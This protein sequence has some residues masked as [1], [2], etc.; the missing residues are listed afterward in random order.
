MYVII[1][2]E[3]TG[4]DAKKH[5]VIEVAALKTDLERDFGMINYFCRLHKD[6]ELPTFIR[7]YTGITKEDLKGGLP[8]YRG[9]DLLTEFIDHDD[10][11]VAH[12][13]PFDLSF[14]FHR[15]WWEAKNFIC[16]RVLSRMVDPTKSASLGD[17]TKRYGIQL[18]NHHRAMYDVYATK[19]VLKILM[20]K[21]KGKYIN[22][23]YSYKNRPLEYIPKCT[24][25]ILKDVPG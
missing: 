9:L 12:H 8:E 10:I 17:V 6:K 1:D 20:P 3:T 2:F 14:L 11:V 19:E 7:D 21:V 15:C 24:E 13:I 22:T 23:L 5:Q 16:T 25:V 4:L 18:T